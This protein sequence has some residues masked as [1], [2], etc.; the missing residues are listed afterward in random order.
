MFPLHGD[1][2]P[3]K[4]IRNEGTKTD[5]SRATSRTCH[6]GTSDVLHSFG[7]PPVTG[8][9][10]TEQVKLRGKRIEKAALTCF[11]IGFWQENHPDTA[12]AHYKTML[13][14][15][16]GTPRLGRRQTSPLREIKHVKGNI[17]KML[18][19]QQRPSDR[20]FSMPKP[21]GKPQRQPRI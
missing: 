3:S 4:L 21:S 14:S 20:V 9:G 6:N 10:S 18:R 17:R 5:C 19:R 2:H 11:R 16:I 7:N 13:W 12:R 15:A 1:V 8:E